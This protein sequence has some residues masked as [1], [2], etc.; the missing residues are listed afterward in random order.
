MNL[1]DVL[2]SSAAV[3][4]LLSV[5][6]LISRKWLLEWIAG[7][8]RH[9]FDTK[10]A[11]LQSDIR[12]KE[13]QIEALRHGA[14]S[15]AAATQTSIMQRRLKAADDFWESVNDWYALSFSAHF[16]GVINFEEA[17]KMAPSMTD[18][19][20]KTFA[21]ADVGPERIAQLKKPD[22]AQP[23]LSD[24]AWALYL[25]Y[26]M[27]FTI[28]AMK[29]KALAIGLDARNYVTFDKANDLL[30][31]ALPEFKG[32]ITEFGHKGYHLL[33]DALRDRMLVEVRKTIE[34]T[35]QDAE[36]V[37]RAVEIL[38][39]A[40]AANNELAKTAPSLGGR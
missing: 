38:K 23:Y 39:A 40:A 30:L 16:M 26:T 18:A 11:S 8:V 1:L 20:R 31:K 22:S 21:V 28:A 3:L 10:L 29:A 5:G 7:A 32:V 14:L 25:A 12:Q 24:F 27:I 15:N 37:K 34:G 36:S 4:A 13:A 33:I 19:Q 6:A 35:A 9:E 17:S 2:F